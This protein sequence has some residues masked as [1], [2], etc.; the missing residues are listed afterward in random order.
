MPTPPARTADAAKASTS[1]GRHCASAAPPP[2]EDL[3]MSTVA[4]IGCSKNP[5]A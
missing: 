2:K 3:D 4:K 1:I 5:K